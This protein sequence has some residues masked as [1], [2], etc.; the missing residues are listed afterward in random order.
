MSTAVV[1]KPKRSAQVVEMP[2]A[3]ANPLLSML[4]QL[5]TSPNF[6]PEAFRMIVDL[7]REEKA[8][9]ARNEFREAFAA[10]QKDAPAV[11]RKGK[12]H[13]IKYARLEDLIE[14]VRPKL[15]DNGF[16]LHHTINQADGKIAIKAILG[17][18]AGHA[19]TTEIV[20]P[21]DTGPGRNNVQAHMSS[22]TYG[23]R[24][25]ALALLGIAPEGEDDDGK[26][27]DAG[28]SP[29]PS[30]EEIA[31]LFALMEETQTE[32]EGF[33]VSLL[34]IPNKDA[35]TVDKLAVAMNLL[36]VKKSTRAKAAAKAAKA[37]SND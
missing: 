24:Y 6:N 4:G 19:E 28:A 21:L 26:T 34:G 7:L 35:L 12:G 15:S 18:R 17:H 32:P 16:S 10:F 5:A 37:V 27:A 36:T 20:L 33:F 30:D 29:K 25:T 11:M 8:E 23:R 13:N 9:A 1:E 3:P 31:K 22:V 14:A 2:A